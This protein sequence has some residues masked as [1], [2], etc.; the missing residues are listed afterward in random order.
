MKRESVARPALL[1]AFVTAVVY[2]V[3][4]GQ[5]HFQWSQTPFAHHILM[6]DAMMHGQLRIR[7]EALEGKIRRVAHQIE[8]QVDQ[9]LLSNPGVTEAIRKDAEALVY[10]DW[11]V[12]GDRLYG[13]W[14]PLTP[15]LMIPFIALFGPNVSD[16]I[17]SILF[18]ATNIG[19]FYWLLCRIDRCGLCPIERSCRLAM[20]ALLAFGTSHLW[21]TCA[22]QIWFTVQVVAQTFLLMA[23]VAACSPA[24]RHRDWFF[25]G[26]AFGAAILA[27]S[28]V[29]L[30]GLFFLVLL[31]LRWRASR[32]GCPRSA[33][34][35]TSALT[36]R[37][38]LGRAFLFI[39]PLIAA[40]GIQSLYNYGRF[41]D[42]RESG[43]EIQIRSGGNPRFIDDFDRYGPVSTHF[44]SRN[45]KYYFWNIEFPR[46]A[47]GRIWYDGEGNSVF[48]MTP[49]LLYLFL[50]WRR[51]TCLTTAALAG[52]VPLIVVLLLFLGTGWQQFGPRYLLDC[53]P[54]LLMIALSGMRGRLT[55][56]GFTLIACAVAMQMFGTPRFLEVSLRPPAPWWA[57]FTSIEALSAMLALTVIGGI[58]WHVFRTRAT[59]RGNLNRRR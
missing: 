12:V 24:N 45:L 16:L 25:S 28:M 32:A 1:L 30:V 57:T 19:L 59:L 38:M 51:W 54:L 34:L 41:G 3:V 23:L 47:D 36:W 9:S 31:F 48:L 55:I 37:P 56:V 49:A 42:F 2:L 52:A 8:T 29:L 18:G 7:P 44:F 15:A 26:M 35:V 20:S 40:F 14:G 43:L 10:H 27:R 58:A 11:A 6:A 46:M 22:G 39:L 17:I 13:Y 4:S 50:A 5:G 33:D 53:T 21:L